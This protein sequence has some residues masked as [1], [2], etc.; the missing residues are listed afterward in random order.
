MKFKN[1]LKLFDSILICEAAGII[2]SFFT[3]SQIES[4]YVTL[5]MPAF[6][7]PNYVFGPVWTTLY[8]LMGV[9]LFLVWREGLNTQHVKKALG[10]F[11]VQLVLNS[12]WSIVF[13]GLH[14]PLGALVVI[15]ALLVSI[16][17]SMIEF[18]KISRAATWLLVPYLLWVSFA[19]YLNAAIWYINK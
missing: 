2:G 6:S 8:A 4:W 17:W 3:M 18:Y 16:V 10:V 1:A 11:A 13:F 7:P 15:V 9:A 14:S 5:Q 12:L 19:T